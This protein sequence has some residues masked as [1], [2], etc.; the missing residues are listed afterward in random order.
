MNLYNTSHKIIA[1]S[2][3]P[4]TSDSKAHSNEIMKSFFMFDP[5][6]F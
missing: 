3:D 6:T 1:F 2:T 5:E 4:S